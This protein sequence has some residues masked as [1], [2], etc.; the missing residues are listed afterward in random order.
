MWYRKCHTLE[1]YP[2]QSSSCSFACI[3]IYIS[4]FC[5]PRKNEVQFETQ[6]YLSV[7]CLQTLGGW[8]QSPLLCALALISKRRVKLVGGMWEDFFLLGKVQK[9]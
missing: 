9:L 2:Y 8:N 1:N 4:S 6:T 5:P 3:F 7:F